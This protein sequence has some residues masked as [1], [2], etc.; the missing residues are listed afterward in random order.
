MRKG[1]KLEDCLSVSPFELIV[2]QKRKIKSMAV[3]KERLITDVIMCVFLNKTFFFFNHG[4][5][6]VRYRWYTFI[7]Y[8]SII[9]KLFKSEVIS[10]Y[11]PPNRHSRYQLLRAKR[12]NRINDSYSS[13]LPPKNQTLVSTS[14]I[15]KQ[16]KGPSWAL[17]WGVSLMINL[18][19]APTIKIFLRLSVFPIPNTVPLTSE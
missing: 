1:L 7:F 12:V 17:V 9:A 10:Q 11:I 3:K 15:W 8:G 19:Q 6:V 4:N 2:T 5:A 16:K 18:Q 13:S 14:P